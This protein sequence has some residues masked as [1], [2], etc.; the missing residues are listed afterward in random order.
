MSR[1]LVLAAMV[2]CSVTAHAGTWY[3]FSDID[4]DDTVFFFDSETVA[5]QGDEVTFWAMAV[6]KADSPNPDGSY[7]TAAKWTYSCSKRTA[8][9]LTVS[10]YD[11]TGQFIRA[12]PNPGKARDVISGSVGAT[13]LKTVCASD[14]PQDKSEKHYSRIGDNNVYRAAK[15]VFASRGAQETDPAPHATWYV[16][17]TVS[18][19]KVVVFFD[20]DT[21]AKDH[22]AVTIWQKTV[23]EPNS[24]GQGGSQSMAQKVVYSCSDRTTQVLKISLYD[25]SGQFMQA[26]TP[27]GRT[28]DI[29]PGTSAETVLETVCR[30]DFPD[31]ASMGSYVAVKDNNIYAFAKAF[32][33]FVAAKRNE[34]APQ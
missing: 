1:I 32:F 12:D 8:Q 19:P 17:S 27:S 13:I 16:F 6:Q 22:G 31:S 30:S 28:E 3:V 18:D 21:V 14:F 9:E 24:P 33:D 10:A 4:A 34:P 23:N 26:V 15:A 11:R 7:S 20:L 25:Q 5:R 2:L 29:V